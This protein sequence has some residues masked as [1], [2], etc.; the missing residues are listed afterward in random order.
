[1]AKV[2]DRTSDCCQVV[3]RLNV[4]DMLLVGLLLPSADSVLNIS[5]KVY[6]NGAN[7]ESV[8]K[9]LT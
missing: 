2:L 4:D 9:A 5:I 6:Q 8:V 1:M 7:L 3:V